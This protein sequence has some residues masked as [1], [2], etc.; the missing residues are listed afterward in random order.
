MLVFIIDLLEF[1]FEGVIFSGVELV[2]RLHAGN[3]NHPPNNS[4]IGYLKL[5]YIKI[6][7]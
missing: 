7:I 5:E 4:I 6:E 2:T 1:E 3:L